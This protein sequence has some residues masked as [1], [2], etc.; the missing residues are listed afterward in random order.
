MQK[1]NKENEIKDLVKNLCNVFD[2]N[3]IGL[4]NNIL[5][6]QFENI[7]SI[8]NFVK[9]TL[10]CEGTAR[11]DWETCSTTF[12]IT[13]L[14]FKASENDADGIEI[15][16]TDADAININKPYVEGSTYNDIQESDIL[17]NLL[18]QNSKLFYEYDGTKYVFNKVDLSKMIYH[19]F[20]SK[21]VSTGYSNYMYCLKC[22][23]NNKKSYNY[24]GWYGTGNYYINDGREYNS[25]IKLLKIL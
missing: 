12:N 21:F 7:K 4:Y 23:L 19:V 16:T 3:I 14:K 17:V 22:A 20:V 8:N 5:D 9:T 24:L 11:W 6:D 25:E 15:L 10:T 13:S 2:F 18:Q 1:K